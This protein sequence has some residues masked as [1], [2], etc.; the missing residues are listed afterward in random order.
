MFAFNQSNLKR[1]DVFSTPC[2]LSKQLQKSKSPKSSAEM[3]IPNVL[4]LITKINI[5]DKI[6]YQLNYY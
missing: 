5:F 2:I 6:H 1:N 3:P 4:E